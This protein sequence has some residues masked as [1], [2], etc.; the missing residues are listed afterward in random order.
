[1]V[2]LVFDGRREGENSS[3]C[4]GTATAAAAAVESLTGDASGSCV[5]SIIST[6]SRA[7]G[8]TSAVEG[9][10]A[11]AGAFDPTTTTV[12]RRPSTALLLLLDVATLVV[13]GGGV[14]VPS[15]VNKKSSLPVVSWESA[16]RNSRSS[17]SSEVRTVSSGLAVKSK[18]LSREDEE[19]EEEEEEDDGA[20]AADDEAL[21]LGR[22]ADCDR[23]DRCDD[24]V[25][26]SSSG[27]VDDDVAV[28]VIAS[29]CGPLLVD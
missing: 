20:T 18:A 7:V 16:V 17:S 29:S 28:L 9:T 15:S 8:A 11:A 10:T 26:L 25:R 6:S 24:A 13:D 1:M 5:M 21:G 14:G 19:E 23:R 27:G 2:A 22:F 12:E 3:R 4:G